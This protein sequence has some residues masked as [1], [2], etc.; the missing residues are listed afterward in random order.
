MEPPKKRRKLPSLDDSFSPMRPSDNPAAHQGRTRA[1]EHVKGQWAAHIYV[2]M[3]P[4]SALRKILEEAIVEPN[5]AGHSAS[6]IHS[7]LR[8][9]VVPI[10]QQ[11]VKNVT[12]VKEKAEVAALDASKTLAEPLPLHLSLSRPLMLQTAQRDE[13][14]RGTQAIAKTSKS[15]KAAFA[16]FAVLENDDLTRRFLGI[17]IGH[18]FSQLLVI[19]KEIDRLLKGMRLPTYYDPP[20]FHCSI[21]WS[22]RTS[23]SVVVED[24]EGLR[25]TLPFGIG[26]LQELE[27]GLGNRLREELWVG[28]IVVKIGQDVSRFALD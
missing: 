1:N 11:N 15:F 3:M 10:S 23:K 26:R 9:E 18:G 7:L 12:R 22:G 25:V 19:V 6:L 5:V 2:E 4:S 8:R 13:L 28:E 14:K 24:V 27:S 16:Q 17:E 21:G 20:R